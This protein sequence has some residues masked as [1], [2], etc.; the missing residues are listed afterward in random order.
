[1]EVRDIRFESAGPIDL[2]KKTDAAKIE[3]LLKRLD[4]SVK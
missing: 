3:T 4:F 1:M 2:R